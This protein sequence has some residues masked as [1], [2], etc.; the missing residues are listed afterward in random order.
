M[1]RSGRSEDD[2]AMRLYEH[3]LDSFSMRGFNSSSISCE[4]DPIFHVVLVEPEIPANT[5]NVARSCLAAGARL[6]LIKPLGFVIDDRSLRRAGLDYWK[7]VD[8]VTWNSFDEFVAG[9]PAEA[10]L[11]FLTT[12]T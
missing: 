4:P 12:K 11:F 6:H 8:V 1:L 10:R 2:S 9:L 5:G 7:E 3:E